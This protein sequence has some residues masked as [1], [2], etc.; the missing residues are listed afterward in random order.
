MKTFSG[1]V[2]PGVNVIRPKEKYKAPQPVASFTLAKITEIKKQAP[3]VDKKPN[4]VAGTYPGF[5]TLVRTPGTEAKAT[6]KKG[7]QQPIQIAKVQQDSLILAP[8]NYSILFSENAL[9]L[10]PE[11][12]SQILNKFLLILQVPVVDW[13]FIFS[14]KNKLCEP[15]ILPD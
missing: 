11:V 3:T 14:L 13:D 12:V 8:R 7:Q 1:G 15:G 4:F 9:E 2:K 5:Q 6:P 10:K